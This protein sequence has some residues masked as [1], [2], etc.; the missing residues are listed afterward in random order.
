MEKYTAT[1][2]CD[3][4]TKI[5]QSEKVNDDEKVYFIQSFLL[6]YYT[7]DQIKWIWE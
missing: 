3:I 6:H 1:E 2:K 5:L 4:I 7:I